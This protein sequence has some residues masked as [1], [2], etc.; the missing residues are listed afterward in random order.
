VT[1]LRDPD[2]RVR[3]Y[4][5]HAYPRPG[6]VGQ[7]IRTSQYRL[8][9]WTNERTSERAFELYDL[10]NDPLETRNIAASRP[11]VRDQLDKVL[12]QQLVPKPVNRKD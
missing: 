3:D 11:T 9:R 8:V 7:A 10:R 12:D 2:A 6:R 5:Y 4:A 1:V